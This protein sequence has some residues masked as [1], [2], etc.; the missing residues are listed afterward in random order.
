MFLTATNLTYYMLEMNYVTPSDV[1]LGQVKIIEAGRR[2]RN[3]KV[4][5][6]DT[7][8]FLKQVKAIDPVENSTLQREA[9]CYSLAR[10]HPEW[11]ESIPRFL[12]YDQRR[13]CLALELLPEA[14]SF[15]DHQFYRRELDSQVAVLIAKMLASFHKLHPLQHEVELSSV[16]LP[17]RVPWILFFHRD[18]NRVSQGVIELGDRIRADLDMSAVIDKLFHGWSRTTWIH[19]D[20]KWDNVLLMSDTNRDYRVKLIDWELFDLGDPLWDVAGFIHSFMVSV[21]GVKLRTVSSTERCDIENLIDHMKPF[22]EF[23][24]VLWNQYALERQFECEDARQQLLKTMEFSAARMLQSAFEGLYY[25]NLFSQEA[26]YLLAL[27]KFIL[28][29]PARFIEEIGLI[30]GEDT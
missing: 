16:S 14:E 29:N 11:S 30:S 5:V 4:L 22:G 23:L 12:G 2:N 8:V 6:R 28:K 24:T 25:K 19:G 3:F 7:G 21:V 13:K 26:E 20:M 17:K 18:N 1:V 10:N 27:S 15:V 9:E